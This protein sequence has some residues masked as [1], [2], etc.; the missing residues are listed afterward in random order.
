MICTRASTTQNLESSFIFHKINSL[1]SSNQK[2]FFL[3]DEIAN[4]TASV[5]KPLKLLNQAMDKNPSIVIF[6][7]SDVSPFR[8][9]II[10]TSKYDIDFF[11]SK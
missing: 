4:S 1:F 11:H 9:F 10:I 5:D 3:L 6:N 2:P 7:D 8:I